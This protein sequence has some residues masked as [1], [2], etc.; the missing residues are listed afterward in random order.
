MDKTTGIDHTRKR[1]PD[2][3]SSEPRKKSKGPDVP[4]LNRFAEKSGMTPDE[5]GRIKFDEFDKYTELDPREYFVENLGDESVPEEEQNGGKDSP[6]RSLDNGSMEDW[7][8][9]TAPD[10]RSE[11]TR[12][13]YYI[14]APKF[15]MDSAVLNEPYDSDESDGIFE[16]RRIVKVD[17]FKLYD[18]MWVYQGDGVFCRSV[19]KMDKSGNYAPFKISLTETMSIHSSDKEE[20]LKYR[21][22]YFKHEDRVTD[23]AALE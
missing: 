2:G 19:G 13:G 8:T 20:Y 16:E 12:K 4:F 22:C 11:E 3:A 17:S 15:G 5:L 10:P 21:M 9:Y 7:K 14:I 23:I 18:F 1:T 6:W